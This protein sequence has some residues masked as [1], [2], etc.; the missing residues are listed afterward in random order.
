MPIEPRRKSMEIQKCRYLLMMLRLARI[1]GTSNADV[2]KTIAAKKGTTSAIQ[3]RT[4]QINGM[5]HMPKP[6]VAKLKR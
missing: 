1:S 2:V 5:M 3:V 6:V 4:K